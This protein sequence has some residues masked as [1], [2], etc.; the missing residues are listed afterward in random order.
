VARGRLLGFLG[1]TRGSARTVFWVLLVC[2]VTVCLPR[3]VVVGV[4]GILV[5]GVDLDLRVG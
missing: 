1:Q 4:R 2:R 3:S 5:S